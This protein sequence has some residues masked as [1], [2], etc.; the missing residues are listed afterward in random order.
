VI[1]PGH[2]NFSPEGENVREFS[3]NA[4]IKAT[5]DDH[6]PN[7]NLTGGTPALRISGPLLAPLAF[8]F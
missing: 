6:I 4:E 8:L 5:G 7:I 3:A 2:L 1:V